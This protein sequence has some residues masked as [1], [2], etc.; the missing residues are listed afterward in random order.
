MESLFWWPVDL[1]GKRKKWKF[2]E[3]SDRTNKQTNK[4]QVKPPLVIDS[5]ASSPA[6]L[7]DTANDEIS[8]H[9]MF[10]FLPK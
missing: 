6:E 7:P 5:S 4:P 3:I 9:G 8:E 1:T 10:P 2:F